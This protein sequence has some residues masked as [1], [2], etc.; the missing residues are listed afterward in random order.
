[1]IGVLDVYGRWCASKAAK[2]HKKYVC[3]IN[4]LDK[5]KPEQEQAFLKALED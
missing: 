2:Y 1:M 5:I 4:S 3:T